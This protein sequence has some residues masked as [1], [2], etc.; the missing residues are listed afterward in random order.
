LEVASGKWQQCPDFSFFTQTIVDLQGLHAGLVGWGD[1]G[2]GVKAVFEALGMRVSL[3]AIPGR[4]YLEKRPPLDDLLKEVDVLSLHCP[5]TPLTEKLM[6][7]KRLFSMKREAILLN[8]ARG[9]LIDEKAL[10]KVL[11][12]GHLRGAGLDVLSEEPPPENHPLLGAPRC[13]LTPHVAWGSQKA[14]RHLLRVMEGNL[15]AWIAGEKR[16]CVNEF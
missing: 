1:I 8:T 5:L 15:A 13:L 3:A 2:Q 16:H 12:A 7:E 14:R 11:E 4:N 6:N 10:R 9:G